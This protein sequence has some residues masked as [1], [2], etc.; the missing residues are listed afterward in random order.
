MPFEALPAALGLLAVL[1]GDV[2]RD[3]VLFARDLPLLL[4]E[5]SLLREPPQRPLL[6]ERRVAADVRRGAIALEVQHVVDDRGQERAVVA[7]EQHRRAHRREVVLEPLRRLEVEVVRRFVEEQH[8]GGTHQ[9]AR[10]PESSALAAAQL[11]DRLTCA[12]RRDRSRVRAAPRRLAA[13]SC[14]RPSRSKRSR[15]LP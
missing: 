2:A 15:S 10:Q 12:Q 13:R 7:D 3:V 5:V 4:V 8:V 14:S 6:D 11:R 9:L 1:T